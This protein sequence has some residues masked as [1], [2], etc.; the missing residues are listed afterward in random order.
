MFSMF[1]FSIWNLPNLSF[2]SFSS[3]YQ[4]KFS[5]LPTLMALE[6]ISCWVFGFSSLF[7]FLSS[8]F[9]ASSKDSS[10]ESYAFVWFTSSSLLFLP[11]RSLLYVKLL[12]FFFEISAFTFPLNFFFASFS[13]TR[14]SFI[15]SLR[16]ASISYFCS[17]TH[18]RIMSKMFSEASSLL[19]CRV[20]SLRWDLWWR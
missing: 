17:G 11:T 2:Q 1:T 4:S 16:S 9:L 15:C 7:L 20:G 18:G 6:K 10:F 8:S 13:S 3:N 19:G 5:T 12:D 14:P